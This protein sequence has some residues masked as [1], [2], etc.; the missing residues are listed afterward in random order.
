MANRSRRPS[1]VR[2][3]ARAARRLLVALIVAALVFWAAGLLLFRFVL[4]PATPLMV[5]R[6][7]ERDA[8]VDYRPVRTDT[9]APALGRAVVAAEDARFCLHDGVDLQAFEQVWQEYRVNGRLRGASTITMQVA[10]NLFLWNGGG[11]VRKALELPLAWAL[12][13]LWPKRRILE[14]YLNIAEWGD[15]VFGAEAAAR[16]HFA[17]SA[18]HL[19]TFQAA[20]LAAVLPSPRRWSASQPG[21]YVVARTGTLQRR[22]G[23]LSQAQRR[24]LSPS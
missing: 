16:A 12:D 2:G 3:I 13:A 20:R 7:I 15:G 23:Q 17:R 1:H 24:C 18:A 14:V 5:I 22:I 19:T 8:W 11:V 21:P 4:P 10:R 9:I 6:S